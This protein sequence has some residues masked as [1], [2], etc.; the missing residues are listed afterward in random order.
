MNRWGFTKQLDQSRMQ[1]PM[2]VLFGIFFIAGLLFL[3]LAD[4]PVNGQL[5]SEGIASDAQGNF[6]R[7]VV[8]VAGVGWTGFLP[9][10]LIDLFGGTQVAGVGWTGYLPGWL[11]DLF[12]GTQVAGVGWTGYLPG[13]LIDLFGAPIA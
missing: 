8:E 11:I 12:G 5:G 13:W 10:W 2:T 7:Q 4:F 3:F 1:S 6:E 9:G